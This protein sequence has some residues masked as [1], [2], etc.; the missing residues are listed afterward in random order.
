MYRLPLWS[1]W[2]LLATLASAPAIAAQPPP[3]ANA[4]HQL[5]GARGLTL[6][7][8]D[9]DGADG[10]SQCTGPCASV[11]PPYTAD[12]G[13][14]ASGDFSVIA[15][16]DHSLQWAFRR[17]PLYRYAGDAKPGDQHGDGINGTWHVALMP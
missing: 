11:W 15:R 4:Q 13:A 3:R 6:Y 8:F 14:A 2:L 16:A 5:T 1:G 10:H 9:T 7:T 17:H 12:A